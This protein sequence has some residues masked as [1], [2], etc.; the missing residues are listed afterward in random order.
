MVPFLIL[1]SEGQEYY[2][3]AEQVI[4]IALLSWPVVAFGMTAVYPYFTLEKKHS[5]FQYHF[6]KHLLV[7]LSLILIVY[8]LSIHVFNL[9]IKV[10]TAILLVLLMV[11][12]YFFSITY[13][14]RNDVKISSFFDA[15]PYV[16]IFL[17]IVVGSQSLFYA[18]LFS[19]FIIIFLIYVVFKEL[20]TQN[21][22]G[23]QNTK[24]RSLGVYYKKSFYSFLVSWIAIVVV[25]FPRAYIP[26]IL[27]NDESQ[28]LYLSLRVAAV[29]VLGY[30]FLQISFYSELYKISNI[31][32]FKLWWVF[33]VGGLIFFLVIMFFMKSQLS[34]WSVFYTFL[35]ISVSF[36]E[37]Q[38]VR[39]SA[40]KK[41]LYRG[42]FLLPLILIFLFID[43]FSGFALISAALLL[44]YIF[45]QLT[46]VFDV[47]ITSR[48]IQL[49][50]LIFVLFG[51]AYV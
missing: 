40:Q 3:M 41:V 2:V 35:W 50:V 11:F 34:V 22:E 12:S 46:S 43:N 14:C 49:P 51:V 9:G 1:W 39:K 48:L 8:L 26:E 36:L 42:I 4:A 27:S 10:N 20:Q 25:M 13:K 33:W 44:M 31:A 18:E 32:F 17:F 19:I 23:L 28:T 30:Q 38:V 6:Y 45:I 15:L 16:F 37:L 5:P 21:K 24:K 29:L 7:S 47:R